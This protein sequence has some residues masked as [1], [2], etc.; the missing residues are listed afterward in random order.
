MRIT[1]KN[2]LRRCP[3]IYVNIYDELYIMLVDSG[4]EVSAISV[5][6]EEE[7]IKKT[8]QLPTLPLTGLSIQNAFGNKPMK[9]ERK[10]L[11]SIEINSHISHIPFIVVPQ[12]NEGGLIGNYLLE[13][14]KVRINYE[15]RIFSLNMMEGPTLNIS[16][17][18]NVS[19]PVHPREVQ[20]RF[21]KVPKQPTTTKLLPTS[22]QELVKKTLDKYPEVFMKEMDKI[23]E[24][25]CQK[26]LKD[27]TQINVRPYPKP[28]A[29]QT[30][31]ILVRTLEHP[32]DS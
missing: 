16:F 32:E 6:Y 20:S 7:I 22:E 21:I 17:I 30:P 12:L 10:V 25:E 28:L 31:V 23:R 3:Y 19:S 27:N 13:T 5:L 15:E 14:H 2:A 24:Y 1:R 18:N 8:G 29:K 4:A 26:R 9:V 11:I